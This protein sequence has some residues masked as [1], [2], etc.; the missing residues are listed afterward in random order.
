MLKKELGKTGEEISAVGIGTWQMG[1]N[2]E[3]VKVIKEGI[4]AGTNFVDTAEYY[5]NEDMV[6]DAVAGMDNIFLATKVFPTHFRYD[7]VI[8]ACNRSLQR[9]GRREIDLYQLHWPSSSVPI[10]ETMRAME[11]LVDEGKVRHIG[12]S[13]FDFG[14]LKDA[15]SAMKKYEIVSNQVEYNPMV[16]YIEKD[17]MDY[18]N[19]ERIS[20]I[21]YS[22]LKHGGAVQ[23]FNDGDNVF[24]RIASAHGV[25]VPQVILRWLVSRRQVL[26][27]PKTSHI[28]HSVQNIKSQ[29]IDLSDEEI[30][31]VDNFVKSFSA[32]ST[33]GKFGGLISFFSRFS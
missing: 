31:D 21:A 25:S 1:R 2:E 12:V 10:E 4:R 27:I 8:K 9:L 13:N 6:G 11:K 16:R 22:P 29:E 33:K 20:I 5:R 19:K 15:Q 32:R 18:C 28:E 7:K 17:I 24:G 23:A 14:Q 30:R 3:S 26:A